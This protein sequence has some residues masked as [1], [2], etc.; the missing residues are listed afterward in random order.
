MKS[1]IQEDRECYICGRTEPLHTHHCLAGAYRQKAE[2][3]GLKVYLCPEHHMMMHENESMMKWM[4]AKAQKIA[5]E[6]YRWTEEEFIE[7][8]G[9][10]FL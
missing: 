5:M 1:I 6:H 10:N 2:E 4:R 3:Y 7:K 8:I 9:R